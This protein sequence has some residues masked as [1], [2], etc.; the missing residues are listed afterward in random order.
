MLVLNT[1]IYGSEL[2][3]AESFVNKMNERIAIDEVRLEMVGHHSWDTTRGSTPPQTTD[4]I[5][6]LKSNINHKLR[7]LAVAEANSRNTL[8]VE[9]VHKVAVAEYDI[10]KI[11]GLPINVEVETQEEAQNLEQMWDDIRLRHNWTYFQLPHK[12]GRPVYEVIPY[13]LTSTR[14]LVQKW[15]KIYFNILKE[16]VAEA[17]PDVAGY[18]PS[19]SN[20]SFLEKDW[21]SNKGKSGYHLMLALFKKVAKEKGTLAYAGL[22]GLADSWAC[23]APAQLK[24]KGLEFALNSVFGLS[25][26]ELPLYN[27]ASLEEL[28]SRWFPPT[29][30]PTPEATPEPTPEPTPETTPETIPEATPEVIVAVPEVVEPTPPIL[31]DEDLDEVV[32]ALS[33]AVEAYLEA[34][35]YAMFG[36][37]KVTPGVHPINISFIEAPPSIKLEGGVEVTIGKIDHLGLHNVQVKSRV[38]K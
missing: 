17:N 13:T 27:N 28:T 29:P 37:L 1:F 5:V 18:I 16:K 4:L 19:F 2:K 7:G 30:E 6:I 11:L 20:S 35:A 15:D 3:F 23:Q 14:S 38:S 8:W 36:N 10:R 9:C 24:K 34:E 26:T 25:I 31:T 12:W 33:E 32:E 22:V 21:A